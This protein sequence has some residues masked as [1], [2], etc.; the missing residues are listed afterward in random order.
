MIQP[1][2]A[3]AAA[4][5]GQCKLGATRSTCSVTASSVRRIHIKSTP[6]PHTP[7][8]TPHYNYLYTRGKGQGLSLYKS[9]LP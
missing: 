6:L 2:Q 7:P 3:G 9:R 5:G 8:K 1:R 4:C